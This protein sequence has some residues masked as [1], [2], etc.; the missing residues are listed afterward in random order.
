MESGVEDVSRIDK[1]TLES[2]LR[3]H[4]IDNVAKSVS[5]AGSSLSLAKP[6]ERTGQQL[7]SRLC[8]SEDMKGRLI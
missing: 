2:A 3:V 1:E 7:Q 4:L 6:R 8:G 5:T